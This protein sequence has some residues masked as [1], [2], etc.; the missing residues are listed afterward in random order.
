MPLASSAV[1]RTHTGTPTIALD[2][3]LIASDAASGA[4]ATLI[5]EEVTAGS[6]FVAVVSVTVK[7]AAGLAVVNVT[8]TSA[9]PSLSNALAGMGTL[10]ARSTLLRTRLPLL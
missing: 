6:G 3:V 8:W 7:V 5:G 10:A 9:S 2:G 1:A 4:A